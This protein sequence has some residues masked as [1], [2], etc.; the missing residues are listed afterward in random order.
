MR[1]VPLRRLGASRARSY[2]EALRQKTWYDAELK[3]IQV[4]ETKGGLVDAFEMVKVLE[5]VEGIFR[6]VIARHNDGADEL[7]AA[8]G[9]AGVRGAEIEQKRLGAELTAM[10]VAALLAEVSK[11]R[12][13]IND[14]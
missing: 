13:A 9:R 6:D 14:T 4:E 2:D 7:A 3:R 10:F 12:N 1:A 11:L 5:R 8:V